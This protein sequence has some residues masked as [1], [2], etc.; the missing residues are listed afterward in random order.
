[1]QPR[2]RSPRSRRPGPTIASSS[3]RAPG[4]PG[5]SP[6]GSSPVATTRSFGVFTLRSSS[7]SSSTTVRFTPRSES[8]P[9]GDARLEVGEHRLR[10]D[11]GQWPRLRDCRGAEEVAQCIGRD[12]RAVDRQHEARLVRR[13]AEARDDPEH[14]RSLVDVVVED[15]KRQL[16]RIAAFPTASTSSQTSRRGRPRRARR[17]SHR[18]TARAPSASRTAPRRLRRAGRRSLLHDPPRL[19][20]DGDATVAHPAA[21]RHA[22]IRASSTAS[23]DGAP[24]ATSTGHPATA[25]FW[26]S[27]NESRPLTHSTWDGEREQLASRNAQPTTLSIALWRPTSSRTHTSVSSR[28]RR[29][30]SR[31]AHRS[32]RTRAV[33]RAAA[34]G[35]HGDHVARNLER[36]LDPRRA[37]LDRLDR[38]LPAHPARGRRV[39]VAAKRSGIE[40]ARLDLD[41]VRREIVGNPR[42]DRLEPLRHAEPERELLVVARRPHRDGDRLSADADLERLLDGD[43][44]VLSRALREPQRVDPA[45]R[46]RRRLATC[47]QR[48]RG[49]RRGAP[50]VDVRSASYGADREH[51][52]R[53]VRPAVA[54]TSRTLARYTLSLSGNDC[55]TA[56]WARTGLSRTPPP[57]KRLPAG[58]VV[59]CVF[60]LML[61][62]E[63]SSRRARARSGQPDPQARPAP[64]GPRD[65]PAPRA[66]GRRR[67]RRAAERAVLHLCGGHGGV[68][69]LRRA[70]AVLRQGRT[71][72]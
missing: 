15:R 69:Q 8:S 42:R 66:A 5:A 19:R 47:D 62:E 29:A 12:E 21:E 33:R 17:A 22:A 16:E 34:P 56:S 32:P 51:R 50:R 10:V 43:E 28:R 72:A 4:A 9:R 1:M 6:S 24:T 49:E 41:R 37:H 14:R 59:V 64:S 3:G 53:P 71:V 35:S 26:T 27:S 13:R 48:T 57:S 31:A 58:H 65:P 30:R 63:T 38:A 36:A 20:V 25:A 39:E 70:D 68:L 2:V 45:R 18:E 54:V 7:S 11:A 55:W 46:V 40:A 23:D 44:V 60:G 61:F 67:S 52:D